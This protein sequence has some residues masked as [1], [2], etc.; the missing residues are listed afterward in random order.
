MRRIGKFGQGPE[1]YAQIYDFTINKEVGHVVILSG[2]SRVC[3]YNLQGEFQI[4]KQVSES[5]L[6]DITSNECGYLMSSHHRTYTEGENAYLLY[7]FDY[8]FNLKGKWIQVLPKRMPTLPLL[9]SALQTAKNKVYYC[10]VFTNSIYT[11]NC[12]IDSVIKKYD[13]HFSAPMPNNILANVMDFMEKQRNYDFISEVVINEDNMLLCYIRQ[14]NYNI[15]IIDSDGTIL[16]NGQYSGHFPKTFRG[17]NKE[18]LSPI[19]ADE[20]LSYWKKLPIIH[21]SDTISPESNFMIL[22]WTMKE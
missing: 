3:V 22:K 15:A 9:S 5:L 6:W 21:H 4:S 18:L 13:I 19:S 10:D 20:Y 8:D 14:G 7:A 16:K 12:D 2:L 11:Y 1:E 17:N